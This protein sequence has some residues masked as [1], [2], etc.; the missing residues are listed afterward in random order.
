MAKKNLYTS[1]LL[2]NKS[3]TQGFLILQILEKTISTTNKQMLEKTV[4]KI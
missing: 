1:F 2:G 4:K 3:K